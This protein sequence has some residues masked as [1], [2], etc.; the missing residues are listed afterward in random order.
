MKMNVNHKVLTFVEYRAVSRVFQ[1]IDPP[2]LSPTSE[3]VLPPHQSRGG[4]HSPVGEGG[5]GSIFRKT[6]RHRIGLLQYV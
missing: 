4:T 6:E 2:P 3:C 1:N 5:G